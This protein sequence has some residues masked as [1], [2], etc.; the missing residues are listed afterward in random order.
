MAQPIALPEEMGEGT[1]K[2]AIP[3]WQGVH[4]GL[5]KGDRVMILS[6]LDAR[7]KECLH[8]LG[9][10]KLYGL[11]D[12]VIHHSPST[13][14][15]RKG[16]QPSVRVFGRILNYNTLPF[17]PTGVHIFSSPTLLSKEDSESFLSQFPHLLI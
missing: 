10:G 8:N 3:D 11:I 7:Y 12:S 5:T 6:P 15:M 2:F 4:Q 9:D 16:K 1:D 17:A 14:D 13:A